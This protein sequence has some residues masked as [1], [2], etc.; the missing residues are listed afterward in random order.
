MQINNTGTINVNSGTMQF[1]SLQGT[2]TLQI[3]AGGVATAT[4]SKTTVGRLVHNGAAAGS[5][6]LGSRTITV[7]N[8]DDNA[9]FG[10]GNAFNRRADVVTTG[11]ATPR[12]LAAG[13]VNQ[14]LSGVAVSNGNK[15]TPS[16]V[17]GKRACRVDHLCLQHREHRQQRAVIARRDPDQCRRRQHH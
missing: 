12:L 14:A 6:D 7:S 4:A 9:N 11:A 1:Q 13:D 5:L 15:T 8:D 10:V 3:G 17:I 16:I 2:G